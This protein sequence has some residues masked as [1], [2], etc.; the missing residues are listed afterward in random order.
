MAFHINLMTEKAQ[1][2]TAARRLAAG[3]ALALAVVVITLLPVGAYQWQQRRITMAEQEALE[4]QY[5]PIRQLT[6]QIRKLR[7][8]AESLVR[9]QRTAL[10]LARD[11]APS[12][13]LALVGKAAAGSDGELYVK[14]V[15]LTQTPV[16]DKDHPDDAERLA[17]EASSSV[18]YDVQRFVKNLQQSPLGEVKVLST[19]MTSEDGKSRKQ[20]GIEAAY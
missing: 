7:A 9:N 18:A 13:L 10:E 2:R 8:E 19:E 1:F 4:S 17:L 11:R 5:E 12:T 20:Y 6:L 14:H 15:T 16:R 3:W